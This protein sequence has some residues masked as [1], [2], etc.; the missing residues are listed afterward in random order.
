[1]SSKTCQRKEKR[2]W[3]WDDGVHYVTQMMWEEK[4]KSHSWT[5]SLFN[6]NDDYYYCLLTIMAIMQL[7]PSNKQFSS[8][9]SIQA[10]ITWV[11]LFSFL[12]RK[13][14]RWIWWWQEYYV[15]F[16]LRNLFSQEPFHKAYSFFLLYLEAFI[17]H[18]IRD[19][20]KLFFLG[21]R[22]M[23]S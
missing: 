17:W 8:H 7:T 21:K 4:V 20:L 14:N 23:T 3:W 22:H 1:M 2:R 9:I 19:I 6:D 11:S 13:E 16:F 5:I 18:L 12:E 10:Y 15:S